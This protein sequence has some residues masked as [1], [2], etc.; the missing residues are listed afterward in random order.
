MFLLTLMLYFPY[1]V[2]CRPLA[3]VLRRSRRSDAISQLGSAA[4]PNIDITLAI[5]DIVSHGSICNNPTACGRRKV[6]H[7]L[8]TEASFLS[9]GYSTADSQNQGSHVFSFVFCFVCF[10][11][12]F[13]V[14]FFF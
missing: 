13:S 5:E 4:E 12:L 7:T 14:C 11:L 6:R 10:F 1:I 9:P 2:L 3:D 8:A